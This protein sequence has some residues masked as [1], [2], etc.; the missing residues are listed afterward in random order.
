MAIIHPIREI[1]GNYVEHETVE[2]YSFSYDPEFGTNPGAGI[3]KQEWRIV[4]PINTLEGAGSK[5]SLTLLAQG[6]YKITLTVFDDEGLSDTTETTEII[7]GGKCDQ[8]TEEMDFLAEYVDSL[9]AAA[10]TGA[11]AALGF[12]WAGEMLAHW[13]SGAGGTVK[14]SPS[15]VRGLF[16]VIR[17]ARNTQSV[18]E[19]NILQELNLLRDGQTKVISAPPIERSFYA[20]SP[21]Q[22]LA[23]GGSTLRSE[24]KVIASR[25]GDSLQFNGVI[26]HYW[27]DGYNWDGGKSTNIPW[28]STKRFPWLVQNVQDDWFNLLR[29]CRG[30]GKDFALEST[31]YA[32]AN[33]SLSFPVSSFAL[34]MIRWADSDFPP[35][36]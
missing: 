9:I 12:D 19:K 29:L 31:W 11:G 15:R 6:S 24:V 20:L 22:F 1:D 26:K 13:K 3:A 30:I 14:I 27:T 2:L 34:S 36:A 28:P 16:T 21:A 18:L 23:S 17:E 7:V 35:Y 10:G 8:H 33:E 5:Y 25:A 4:T 32:S